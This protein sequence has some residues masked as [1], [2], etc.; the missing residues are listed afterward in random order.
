M[1]LQERDAN[2]PLKK[3]QSHSTPQP[4]S[5]LPR[6][7]VATPTSERAQSTTT[8]TP[9]SA[10]QAQSTGKITTDLRK[11]ALRKRDSVVIRSYQKV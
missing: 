11:D 1:P 10:R 5:K 9:R 6:P 7:V 3:L 2:A 4:H 8:W